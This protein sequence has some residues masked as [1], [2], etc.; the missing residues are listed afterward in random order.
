M[1]SSLLI[2]LL[3]GLSV[4]AWSYNR[5]MRTTGQNTQKAVVGAGLV[6]VLL[7]LATLFLLFFIGRYLEA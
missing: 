7:F 2:A 3:V 5:F 6:A 4:F 1:F